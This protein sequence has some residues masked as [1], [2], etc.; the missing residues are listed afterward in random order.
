MSRHTR[1]RG[2]TLVELMIVVAIIG[3]LAAIAVPNFMRFQARTKPSEAKMALRAYFTAQRSFFGEKD[4]FSASSEVGF[5]PEANNRYDYYGPGTL[6][7]ITPVIPVT[8]QWHRPDPAPSMG[9]AAIIRDTRRFGGAFETTEGTSVGEYLNSALGRATYN[10]I[11][12]S[13]TNTICPLCG[14]GMM[15][16]G[17]L[18]NDE[19]QDVWYV[20]SDDVGGGSAAS[21][22]GDELGVVRAG[23]PWN[24]AND[25]V[26]TPP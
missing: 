20:F 3:L 19:L 10:A 9:Y 21:C 15:A 1:L 16:V 13:T 8:A 4:R 24:G 11:T 25:V 26:C 7:L 2:F 5:S 17:N 6:P 14:V 18:D 22:G 12:G 23:V